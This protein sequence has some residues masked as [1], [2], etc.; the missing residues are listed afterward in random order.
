MGQE[1]PKLVTVKRKVV[2]VG[3]SC[4]VSLPSSWVKKHGIKPGMEI[5]IVADTLATIIPPTEVS[6]GEVVPLDKKLEYLNR[7]CE[8]E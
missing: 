4:F 7:R 3:N 1:R 2:K 6:P 5:V 8:G